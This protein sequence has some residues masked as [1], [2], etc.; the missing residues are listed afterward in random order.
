MRE[1]KL[2]T[3][4]TF[5][6]DNAHPYIA[7]GQSYPSVPANGLINSFP[8]EKNF[9]TECIQ[10]KLLRKT[11]F[12]LVMARETKHIEV[13]VDILQI[14]N[15]ILVP[16]RNDSVSH[17]KLRTKLINIFVLRPFQLQKEQKTNGGYKHYPQ[18]THGLIKIFCIT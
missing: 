10:F 2:T 4:L 9:F 8:G 13:K 18:T 15:N 17:S 12:I 7:R 5:T 3:M 16:L 14:C 1:W 6:C 11:I